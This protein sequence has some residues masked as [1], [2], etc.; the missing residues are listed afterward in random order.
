MGH[1]MMLDEG[2]HKVADR[3]DAWV[4]ETLLLGASGGI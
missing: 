4:R 3:I 2:W 1:D